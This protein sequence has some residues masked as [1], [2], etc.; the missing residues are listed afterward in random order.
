MEGKT[1]SSRRLKQFDCLFLLTRAPK[2]YDM[3][4]SSWRWAWQDRVSEQ[5]I[6]PVRPRPRSIFFGLRP[7]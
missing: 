6:R 5:N 7:V 2:F 4:T 3:K 1:I